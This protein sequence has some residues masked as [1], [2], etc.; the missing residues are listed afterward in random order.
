M[1]RGIACSALFLSDGC[2]AVET[3][4]VRRTELLL[5]G[6]RVLLWSPSL[7]RPEWGVPLPRSPH[8]RRI[9]PHCS[10]PRAL[11]S[12]HLRPTGL[13]GAGGACRRSSSTDKTGRVGAHEQARHATRLH[14]PPPP[15]LD[16]PGKRET[17]VSSSRRH[18]RGWTGYPIALG[19]STSSRGGAAAKLGRA[20]RRSSEH[21][22][23]PE[24]QPAFGSGTSLSMTAASFP[25]RSGVRTNDI[26]ACL[27][28]TTR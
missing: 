25:V 26:R 22:M 2:G 28:F 19:R 23:R 4:S 14:A 5:G 24:L 17:T 18:R 20:P 3:M 8:W 7:A 11:P 27:R 9:C 15:G 6:G 21:P 16:H 13:V 10:G 12:G 1:S